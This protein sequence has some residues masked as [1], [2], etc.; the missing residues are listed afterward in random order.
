MM[1]KGLKKKFFLFLLIF[2]LVQNVFSKSNYFSLSIKLNPEKDFTSQLFKNMNDILFWNI[3]FQEEDFGFNEFLGKSFSSVYFSQMSNQVINNFDKI[4]L[5][6]FI[7]SVNG[8]S[9]LSLSNSFNFNFS[10]GDEFSFSKIPF[11][12][13]KIDFNSI[14]MKNNFFINLFSDGVLYSINNFEEKNSECVIGINL[15]FDLFF[16]IFSDSKLFLNE[17][18]NF[19]N[20][21]L[22]SM[23]FNYRY[24]Y[25]SKEFWSFYFNLILNWIIFSSV[26][27]DFENSSGIGSGEGVKLNLEISNFNFGLLR[28]N[29]FFAGIHSIK[30]LL[31]YNVINI[32]EIIY[33]K[34]L[35]KNFSVGVKNSLFLRYGFISNLKE[36]SIFDVKLKTSVFLR[37]NILSNFY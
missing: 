17:S 15:N 28:F 6:D 4:Y 32:N 25:S 37:V 18:K 12:N 3:Y 30:N 34:K 22:T 29:L 27:F 9:N 14:F 21:N 11:N 5:L 23:G 7:F 10:F 36:N 19:T 35:N 2:F 13:F 20:C 26:N 16:N 8:L 1:L 31:N 33:E 24:N